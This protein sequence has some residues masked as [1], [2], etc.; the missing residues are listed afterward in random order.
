MCCDYRV[1][2]DG[3]FT[4]GLNE[5]QL[6]LAAPYWFVNTFKNTVGHRVAE[7]ALG[8]GTLF[9]PL[10]AKAVHLVDEVLPM[11]EVHAGS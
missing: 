5:T 9:T 4:I 1:M 10:D 2:A 6:G 3:K 11:G 7:R 8:L